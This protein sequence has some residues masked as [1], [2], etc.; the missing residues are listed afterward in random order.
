[1]AAVDTAAAPIDIQHARQ[2]AA[3]AAPNSKAEQERLFQEFLEWS[4]T[5]R[6]R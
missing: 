2:Q 1:M 6:G 3:R 4:R 5:K